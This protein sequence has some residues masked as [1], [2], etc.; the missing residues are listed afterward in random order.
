VLLVPLEDFEQVFAVLQE[1]SR[2]M[3]QTL[4][5]KGGLAKGAVGCDAFG[6]GLF[7]QTLVDACIS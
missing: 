6:L 5:L 7:G 3:G 1:D 4:L 2:S